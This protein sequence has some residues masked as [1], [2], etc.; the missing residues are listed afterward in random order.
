MPPLTREAGD[1]LAAEL[2][3]VSPAILRF[4]APVPYR[5]ATRFQEALVAAVYARQAAPLLLLLEHPLVATLGRSAAAT[6]AT[7]VAMPVE[8][9]M[10]GG[11]IT[12]HGPGQVV[13]YPIVSLR[14]AGLGVH[15]FVRELE[16]WLQTAAHAFGAPAY[17]RSGFTGLWT[18]Y[19][20]LASIGI[21]VRRG[22]SWH[23]VAL[24]V[25]DQ[26]RNF[27]GLN[28]C[29]LPGVIPDAIERYHPQ[30]TWEDVA[31]ELARGFAARWGDARRIDL[32]VSD[33]MRVYG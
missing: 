31:S 24:Y 19:G 10:R 9:S 25:H 29:A 5:A 2:A 26:T 14:R 17:I 27:A 1:A 20:K 28:P 33:I 15:E 23:G 18:D 21:A 13:G 12:V 22:V 4:D 30:V 11:S 8:R 7:G 3:G 16:T 6:L 32:A